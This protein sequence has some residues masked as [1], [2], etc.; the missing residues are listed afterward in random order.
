MLRKNSWKS[1]LSA[2]L[3]C[4]CSCFG[5][6]YGQEID[7]QVTINT[8]QLGGS[9]SNKQYYD[10][11]QRTIQDFITTRKWTPDQF[12]A[13][14]RISANFAFTFTKRTTNQTGDYFTGKLQ[15]SYSRPVFGSS[16]NSP[17]LNVLDG[18]FGF[19][20]LEG[21]FLDFNEGQFQSLSSL[22]GF[23]VNLV[24]A[25]DYDSYSPRGGA[26]YWT[27]A[28]AVVQNA[29]SSELGWE[30]DKPNNLNRFSLVNDIGGGS[31]GIKVASGLY[32]YHR[33]GLDVCAADVE[34]GRLEMLEGLE[35]LYKAHQERPNTQLMQ[36]LVNTKSNEFIGAFSKLPMAERGK[37]VQMLKA[38]DPKQSDRYDAMLKTP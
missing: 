13:S 38:L 11:M 10:A 24:L 16:Y 33:L 37:A 23:Y 31:F 6:V 22:I 30:Q 32:K 35:D 27:R 5:Q 18:S 21:Q 20:F 25:L 7:A 19:N 3:L 34:K 26:A 15:V 2:S 4:L 14:E 28:R 8:Q 17:V 29:P 36:V 9:S 12:S 1:W